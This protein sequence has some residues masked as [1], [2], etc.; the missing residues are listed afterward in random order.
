MPPEVTISNL[1]PVW[2]QW[3]GDFGLLLF[4]LAMVA[5]AAKLWGV[6]GQV[7]EMLQEVQKIVEE[8]VHRDM[9]P[10]VKAITK[11]VKTISDDA[12][13]TTHNVTGTVNRVSNVVG[14][15]AGKLESPAIKAVG[16]IT[17]I[18]AGAR[19]LSGNKHK[20]VV[21]VQ[22]KRGGLLGI[23]KK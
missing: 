17:G 15:V 10:D 23:L 5:I 1:P 9:M 21:V 4:G 18:I 11:N 19:A 6:M 20:D 2:V 14:S 12:A 13:A 3:A 16:T 22:K 7:G 8:D